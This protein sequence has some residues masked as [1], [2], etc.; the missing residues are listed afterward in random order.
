MNERMIRL[1]ERRP[2]E[3][4]RWEPE[5]EPPQ[6]CDVLL[7][8]GRDNGPEMI[9][10][11]Y[12]RHEQG[13]DWWPEP[14]DD[15]R[16]RAASPDDLWRPARG[17]GLWESRYAAMRGWDAPE[18]AV[19]RLLAAA[20]QLEDAIPPEVTYNDMDGDVLDAIHSAIAE[21]VPVSEPSGE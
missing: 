10:G 8:H 1:S 7:A 12:L 13:D 20:K 18:G 21:F 5:P 4:K 15:M 6:A 9:Y 2:A 3:A 16:G 19:A 14:Y 11:H 17:T